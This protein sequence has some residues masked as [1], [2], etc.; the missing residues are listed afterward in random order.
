MAE[1]AGRRNGAVAVI[2]LLHSV[3]GHLHVADPDPFAP[4]P[5]SPPGVSP[6][7][8]RAP[9]PKS[10]PTQASDISVPMPCYPHYDE[11]AAALTWQRALTFL[12]TIQAAATSR[13]VAADEIVEQDETVVDHRRAGEVQVEDG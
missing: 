10:S 4:L 9:R 6:R 8:T 5:R 7:P 2:V 3:F 13:L 11:Q 1:G 12:D